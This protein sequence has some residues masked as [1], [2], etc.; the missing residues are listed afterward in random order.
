MSQL[1]KIISAAGLLSGDKDNNTKALL[2]AL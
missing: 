1:P 2:T